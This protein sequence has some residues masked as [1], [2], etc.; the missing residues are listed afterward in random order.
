MVGRTAGSTAQVEEWLQYLFVIWYLRVGDYGISIR[1]CKG[2]GEEPA[3]NVL[4]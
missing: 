2:R 4:E 1:E 3:E